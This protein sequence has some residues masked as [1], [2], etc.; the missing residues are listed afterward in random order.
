[1]RYPLAE[2]FISIN[3]EGPRAGTL[4]AFL[5]V[6]GCNLSCN[7]CDTAW[8][9]APDCPYDS[10]STEEILAWL[11]KQ[12]VKNVTLTGGEP[13][14][15]PDIDQL[16][17]N[18]GVAGYAVEIETNGSVSL[19]SFSTLP[20]R[21]S[22]TMDYKC[23]GSDMESFM[24]VS[25]FTLLSAND[26]VKFVVSSEKDLNRAREIT[27]RYRLTNRCHVY[28]SAVFGRIEPRDIVTYMIRHRWNDVHLQLQMHK[29]IWPPEMR[30]V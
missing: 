12:D 9:N 24:N 5:R 21:P 16:I 18:M 22:F 11:H 13:L 1:M 28:L 7:Y 15:I 10:F 17:E 20:H 14:L 19:K 30:G 6:K 8:A 27:R 23:P 4:A 26:T 29:F 3:G 25:N 2:K